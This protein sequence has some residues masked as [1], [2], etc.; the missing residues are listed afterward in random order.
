MIKSVLDKHLF[1]EDKVC[2]DL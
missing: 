2:S 1:I